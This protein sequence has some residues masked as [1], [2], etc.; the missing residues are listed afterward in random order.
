MYVKRI[1]VVVGCRYCFDNVRF[2]HKTAFYFCELDSTK[3][4]GTYVYNE[5]TVKR[6]KENYFDL[7]H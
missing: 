2:L 1:N 4:Y 6:E 3:N 5:F 7:K